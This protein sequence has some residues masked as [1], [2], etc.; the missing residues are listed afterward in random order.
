[1]RMVLSAAFAVLLIFQPVAVQAQQRAP[2][3][4]PQPSEQT[5]EPLTDTPEQRSK[6]ADAAVVVLVIAASVAA[7]KA[8]GKPCACPS[9]RMSNGALCGN[10][11]AWAKPGGFKPLCKHVHAL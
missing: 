4:G 2:L 8:M 10:R 1:M 6:L 9:D 5:Q 7:Y 11:S 3:G